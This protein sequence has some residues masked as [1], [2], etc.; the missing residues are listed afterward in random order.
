MGWNSLQGAAGTESCPDQNSSTVHMCLGRKC[1]DCVNLKYL[2]K[3]VSGGLSRM[4]KQK[5]ERTQGPTI[6]WEVGKETKGK[7]SGYQ[8]QQLNWVHIAVCF[9]TPAGC[10]YQLK[11]MTLV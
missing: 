3:D 10:Q 6:V 2:T 7:V 11:M 4:A 8:S 1:L 9:R 5:P